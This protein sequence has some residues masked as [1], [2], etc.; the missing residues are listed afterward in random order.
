MPNGAELAWLLAGIA[1]GCLLGA[2]LH[3]RIR[4]RRSRSPAAPDAARDRQLVATIAEEL[5]TLVSGIEGR[6]HA[7]IERAPHRDELPN[8]AAALL[9]AIGQARRLQRKLA[10][11]ATPPPPSIG[12]AEWSSL[13]PGVIEELQHQHLG[14]E[15]RWRPTADLPHAAVPA[16]VLREALLYTCRALLHSEPGAQRLSL[17]AELALAGDRPMLRLGL[18]LE[19]DGDATSEARPLGDD[20]A[21]RLAQTAALNLLAAHGGDLLLAHRPGHLAEA[22]LVLPIAGTAANPT[23]PAASRPLPSAPSEPVATPHVLPTDLPPAPPHHPYGGVL[24]LESDPAVRAMLSAE[25]KAAQRAVFVCADPAAAATLLA[26]TPE[27]FEAL[28]VDQVARLLDSAL[29]Q[30]VR[31]HAPRLIVCVLAAASEPLPAWPGLRR[32]AKP[33]T[34][35][36]LRSALASALAAR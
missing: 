21:G 10:A 31:T 5:A 14:I 9:E 4:P 3:R 12:T 8:A 16:G 15:V 24:L 1:C 36:E 27:R 34:Q 25:L 13:I 6:A 30:A 32:I 20:A 11:F 35:H 29:A 33:F 17:D 26:A 19:W 7:L 22:M 23:A 28:L 18:V 2:V